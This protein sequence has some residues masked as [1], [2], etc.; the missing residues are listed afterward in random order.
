MST[1]PA[2]TLP[3]E[4]APPALTSSL[5]GAKAIAGRFAAFQAQE[6][7]GGTKADPG[8]SEAPK[9]ASGAEATE[10]T[11]KVEASSALPPEKESPKEEKKPDPKPAATDKKVGSDGLTKEERA[12]LVRFKK[13]AERAGELEKKLADHEL[14]RKERDELKELHAKA[15]E[16]AKTYEAKA[17]AFDVRSSPE[18]Q[19]SIIEPGER[20]EGAMREIIK[21][22]KLSEEDVFGAIFNPSSVKGNATLSE[23]ISNM[24]A[25]TARRFERIVGDMRDLEVRSQQLIEKAPEAW[26]AIQANSKKLEEESK[27]KAKETYRLASEDVFSQM[28]QRFPF[29]KEEA[30]AKEVMAEA[31]S[32]DFDSLT[33]DKKAYYAQSGQALL[34]VNSILK[35]K[36]AEIASLKAA[37][38]K[39]GSEPG[40]ADG[41]AGAA[42]KTVAEVK[43]DDLSKMTPGERMVAFVQGRI[44]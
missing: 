39:G 43:A 40:P 38:K 12:D 10:T 37:L 25:M 17:M 19:K 26:Q 21:E 28:Q 14:T 3:S 6:A 9:P 20:L 36:D 11:P 29:L 18:F 35:A 4:S 16:R 41:G 1:P 30:V 42:S 2:T 8:P 27:A 15:E 7:A 5:G 24:D 32:L 23:Y 44:S 22:F 31:S 33:P 34:H 13:E